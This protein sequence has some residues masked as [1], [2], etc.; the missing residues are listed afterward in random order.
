[1][2][3]K[4]VNKKCIQPE[5]KHISAIKEKTTQQQENE[6]HIANG[7]KKFTS[8]AETLSTIPSSL[9]LW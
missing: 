9:S 3:K 4:N 6:V 7:E 2:K 5:E 8:K 1:M